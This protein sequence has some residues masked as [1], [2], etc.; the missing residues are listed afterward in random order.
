MT[1]EVRIM[2]RSIR[3][4]AFVTDAPYLGGAERYIVSMAQA[5]IA[6]D[7]QPH[8]LW[9]KPTL[10]DPD[11]FDET[12]HAGVP[13]TSVGGVDSLR[14]RWRAIDRLIRETSPDAL[15]VNASGRR[16]FWQIPWLA[17]R[18]GRPCVW[19]HHMVDGRDHRRLKA[20]RFGGRVQGPGLWRM[21]QIIRHSMA[22]AGA[23][24]VVTLNESDRRHIIGSHRVPARKVHVIPNGIDTR[25]FAFDRDARRR[26][27][28]EWALPD[29]VI[30]VGTAGRFVVGKGIEHVIEAIAELIS[31]GLRV[32]LV[33]AG[34][35]PDEARL[36]ELVRQRG[37]SQRVRF[38][39]F[40]A[41]MAPFYSGLDIFASASATESFG[42]V[43]TEAMAC[44]RAVVATPTAGAC[45]QLCHGRNGW[46]LDSFTSSALADALEKLHRAPVEVEAMGRAARASVEQ[47]YSVERA[48]DRT[49]ALLRPR[50]RSRESGSWKSILPPIAPQ[51]LW[52]KQR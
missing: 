44:G 52:E 46:L 38:Q 21:P 1:I 22:A 45:A 26:M 4:L 15:I 42:L 48:L 36:K 29:D 51:P 41:D 14:S 6:R 49:M 20:R 25:R 2:T 19:V 17:R 43:L 33:I 9:L 40:V 12:S 3:R 47:R 10:A 31:R 50:H 7:V 11:V 16:G 35:G 27:R 32:G 18:H 30:V 24:A 5:A 28:A 39:G 13:V 23:S 37:I 8:V 34:T